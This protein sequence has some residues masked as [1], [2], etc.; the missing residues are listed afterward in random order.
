MLEAYVSEKS[1]TFHPNS[2]ENAEADLQAT[3]GLLEKRTSPGRLG[4]TLD[5][6]GFPAYLVNGRFEVEWANDQARAEIFG[7]T[8]FPSQISERDIFSFLLRQTNYVDVD[9]LVEF[10]M[11]IAKNRMPRSALFNP[12]RGLEET[13]IESLIELYDSCP[14]QSSRMGEIAHLDVSLAA[15]AGQVRDYD[16]YASFFREGIFFVYRPSTGDDSSL[17]KF[18]GRRDL[19]IR[20]LLRRREPYL[21]DVAVLVA[22]LQDSVKICAELPAH[23]YFELINEIWSAMEANLRKFYATHGKHA[24]DGVLYYFLP[25][26]DSNHAMNAILCACEMR[27]TMQ[28]INR[29]WRTRKNWTNDLRLNI[30]IHTGQ[31]WFGTYQTPTHIEFT[32]LGDT[33]NTAARLSDFARGG[34]IWGSKA[35]LGKLTSKE[36]ERLHYGIRRMDAQGEESITPETFGRISNLIDLADG[37]NRK[38]SDIAVVPVTEIFDIGSGEVALQ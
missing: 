8:R 33:V 37:K 15:K 1:R 17:M 29:A 38:L 21:T 24:G 12:G 13:E 34:A 30:G 36:C 5:E 16:V 2:G 4:L 14:P 6:I 32:V 26:P 31:E 11:A 19:L 10:H 27:A 23:Q 25:Q 3:N 22:D 35:L 20:D 7:A 18:L 28:K 9:Y